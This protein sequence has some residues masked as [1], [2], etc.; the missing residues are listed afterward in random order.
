MYMCIYI[1][2]YVYIHIYIHT[3]IHFETRNILRQENSKNATEFICVGNLLF[4]KG[5][6]IKSGLYIQ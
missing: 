4:S 5:S 3:H 2:I 6:V 1:C